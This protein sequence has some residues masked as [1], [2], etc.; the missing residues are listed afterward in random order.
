MTGRS[1]HGEQ[2]GGLWHRLAAWLTRSDGPTPERPRRLIR[3]WDAARGA[4]RA[5]D[6][7]DRYDP[8]W[9]AANELA[10]LHDREPD[11]PAA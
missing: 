3:V 2:H 11:R 10:Q 4:Y 1:L 7:G 8:L 9:P 5:V 6:L